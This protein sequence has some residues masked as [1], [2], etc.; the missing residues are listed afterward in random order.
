M[1]YMNLFQQ[2]SEEVYFTS[3]FRQSHS[4]HRNAINKHTCGK[5]M[6]FGEFGL[7]SF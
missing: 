3:I 1:L 2:E 6:H 5:K 4:S 7:F